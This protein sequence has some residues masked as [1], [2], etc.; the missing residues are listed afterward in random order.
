MATPI[1]S[2][3]S[4]APDFTLLDQSGREVRLAELLARGPLVLYFYPKDYTAGCT[5]EACS[6]RDAQPDFAAAG[7][8]VVGVSDDSV[9]Q[10]ERFASDHALAFTLLSDPGGRVREL[11]GVRRRFGVL[12]GRITFVIDPSGIVRHVFSSQLRMQRHVAEALETVRRL[13][14]KPAAGAG[15]TN[16]PPR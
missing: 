10:H 3:G 14:G 13:A 5:L 15:P 8:T 12:P 9:E 6:F 2:V 11:Y 4:P 7:A 1:P 16:P